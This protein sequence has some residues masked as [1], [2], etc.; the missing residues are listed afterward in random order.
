MELITR[1]QALELFESPLDELLSAADNLRRRFSKDHFD[2]CTI[3]N[4]KSGSC[5][6]NCSISVFKTEFSYI[7]ANPAVADFL[8]ADTWSYVTVVFNA[9]ST[10]ENI[11]TG[12]LI[13][14]VL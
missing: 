11:S 1:R 8:V 10:N 13:E 9:T 5:S 4:A 6:E 14:D 7:D 2:L 12:I 3:I